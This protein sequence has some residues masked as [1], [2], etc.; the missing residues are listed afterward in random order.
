VGWSRPVSPQSA[1]LAKEQ[2]DST[3]SIG[4]QNDS[5]L[6]VGEKDDTTLENGV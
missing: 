4:E 6:L 5:T 2:N 1:A 3:L